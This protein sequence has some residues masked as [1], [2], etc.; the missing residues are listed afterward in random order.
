METSLSAPKPAS[1]PDLDLARLKALL[2]ARPVV[3]IGMMGA[4][5]TSVGRR[6]AALLDWSFVDSDAEIEEAAGMSI[7]D[8][9]AAHGEAEFRSGEARVIARLL[10]E[11]EQVLATGGGAFMNAETRELIRQSAVS[12]F[13]KADLDLLFERVSRRATRPLLQTADP[14]GTLAR[15]I[16]ERYPTYEEADIVVTSADVP[17]DQVATRIAEALLA[18][19][20]DADEKVATA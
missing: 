3:L 17:Q 6:L 7:P 14:R 1:S 15:L 13:I 8:F 2:G 4:G 11:P 10:K 19:L 18:Q 20:G 5:K 16:E 9:F 12:V